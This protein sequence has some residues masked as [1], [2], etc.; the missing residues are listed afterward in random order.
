MW[1][2]CMLVWSRETTLQSSLSGTTSSTMTHALYLAMWCT[3]LRLLT[4]TWPCTMDGMHVV[5]MDGMWKTWPPIWTPPYWRGWSHTHNM[6]TMSRRTPSQQ[7]AA[8]LRVPF[9]ISAHYLPVSTVCS[10]STCYLTLVKCEV[11]LNGVITTQFI[12]HRKRS[13]LEKSVKGMKQKSWHWKSVSHTA[14]TT[15]KREEF[16]TSVTDVACPEDMRVV[17]YFTDAL[18]VR[19]SFHGVFVWAIW[20]NRLP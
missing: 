9:N 4:R 8:V 13:P 12:P 7:S 1:P 10:L 3:T 6:L 16:A 19:A 18:V 20:A 5:V 15:T 17:V 14:P 2:N 11:Y